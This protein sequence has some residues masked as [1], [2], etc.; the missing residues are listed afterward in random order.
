M[1]SLETPIGKCLQ[2]ETVLIWGDGILAI[3]RDSTNAIAPAVPADI[4][5]T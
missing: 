4:G 5:T 2:L 3:A 1:A